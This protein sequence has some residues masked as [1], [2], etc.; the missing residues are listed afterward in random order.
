M[1]PGGVGMCQISSPTNLSVTTGY[2]Y[3][4]RTE[5]FVDVNKINVV[6]KKVCPIAEQAENESRTL[7]KE[8]TAGLR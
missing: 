7:W 5:T 2:L 3:V 8:V 1:W 6:K 4:Q